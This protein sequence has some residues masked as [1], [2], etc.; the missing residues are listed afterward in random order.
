MRISKRGAVTG[1]GV[2][3][4]TASTFT[5]LALTSQA[6]AASRNGKCDTGEF[7]LNFNSNLKGSWSDFTG[8]VSDYGAKQPGCY[9]FKSAGGGKGKCVKNAAGGFWNKTNKSVTIYFNSGY[10][11][12]SATVKPGA[13]GKLP[14]A[15][16]NENAGHRIGGGSTPPPSGG[17]WA[18]PVPS[19]AVITAG[20]TYPSGRYHGAIDYS[21]FNGKFKSACTGTVDLVDINWNYANKNAYG[22]TGSTNYFWVNCGNGIRI[23]Y[24]HWYQRDLGS[25]KK[26]TKVTAGQTLVKVGNQGNSS[27][28]HLHF[29]VR[30]NGK[31]INGHNFLKSKGVKGLPKG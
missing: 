4:L 27:G 9:D 13:K 6:D 31:Q 29:E 2:L 8:S 3:A 21:G 14:A 22:V 26:G 19:T 12:K 23:G 16:Y 5:G 30:Q 1:L 7:C 18:S 15:V 11:G 20:M 24:A 28:Q 17:K 10:S 25:I